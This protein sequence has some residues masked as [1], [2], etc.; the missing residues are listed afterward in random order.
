MTAGGRGGRPPTGPKYF[1]SLYK[2][3]IAWNGLEAVLVGSEEADLTP[4]DARRIAD[5]AV[6]EWTARRE[7]RRKKTA[8]AEAGKT[9]TTDPCPVC[10]APAQWAKKRRCRRCGWI[11]S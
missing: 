4:R 8:A 9:P 2:V 3:P 6:A 7:R 10:G 11:E 1:K 5:K